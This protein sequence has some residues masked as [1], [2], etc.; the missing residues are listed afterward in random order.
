M[1][2][3]KRQ[4][5]KIDR[6]LILGW[7]ALVLLFFLLRLMSLTLLPVFADEAIYVRWA[8]VMRAEP[9]LRFLPLSDG[10][11]PFFMWLLMFLL[12]L[13]EDPLLVG[14]LISVLAGFGSFIGITL[15]S[16]F[17]F[18]DK[19]ISFLSAFLYTVIPYF[20]FFD[21]L[22]LVD[23][24]LSMLA[25]WTYLL[26]VLLAHYL[27]LDLAMITGIILGAAFLTKSPAIFV[28]FL[29]LP[30]AL[31]L[32]KNNR[33]KKPYLL[34]L[35]KLG[36][37]WLVVYFFAFVIYNL[38]RL[39]PNFGMIA[40]RNQDYIFPI[41]EVF[42]HPLDP[43]K[44][45]LNDLITWLPNLFTPPVIL[46]IFLGVFMR[47][48]MKTDRRQILFLVSLFIVPIFTQSAVA[49]VFAPRYLLFAVWPAVILA[50]VGIDCLSKYLGRCN[51]RLPEG[52]LQGVI[53]TLLLFFTLSYVRWLLVDPAQAPL[54][55]KM[56]SG[57]LEEWTSGYGIKEAVSF[58]NRR[59]AETNRNILVGTEGYFGTLPDGFQMYFDQNRRVIV[60]GVGQPVREVPVS[61]LNATVDNEVYLLVNQ[62]RFLVGQDARLIPI[63]RYPK[64]SGPNGQ[65]FLLL[66]QV[67]NE[68]S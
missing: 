45:H 23:S 22:A 25:V 12:P 13:T 67:K 21:R 29:I 14:R 53:V 62:S 7:T 33:L 64:A 57:Y 20:V 3:F 65:D 51:K 44:P 9:T 49:R 5:S 34:Q 30:S 42:R 10:K 19:K 40:T 6:K 47:W 55:R 2:N 36:G 61:L 46:L 39:G 63:A 28:A 4:I 48:L 58:I 54:P 37:F 43:L 24:L 66:F 8:Q 38:L 35:I 50:A 1:A 56:R 59:V 26:A 52:W 18:R 16:Y 17:L 32:H 41:R 11:Q 31:F 68:S 15:L 27:R 60:V